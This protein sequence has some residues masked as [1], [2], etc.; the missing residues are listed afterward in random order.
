MIIQYY[1]DSLGMPRPNLV[2]M[3]QRYIHLLR[4]ALTK[5]FSDE[6]ICI[7]DRSRGGATLTDLY[8]M[9]C[10]DSAYIEENADVLIIH[11]GVVDCAPRPVPLF[12][13]N[14]ISRMPGFIKKKI[15]SLIHKNR[16]RILKAG[17]TY[18]LT[19]K[20]KFR[21]VLE[22]WLKQ[23][24]EKFYRIYFISIAPTNEGIEKHSPGFSKSINEYN[25]IAKNTI[26]Q[27]QNPKI[28]FVDVHDLFNNC[29]YELDQLVVKEDGHHLTPLGHRVCAAELIRRELSLSKKN[30]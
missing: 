30:A 8:K 25:S 5:A 27:F 15:I 19:D 7:L 22:N 21:A 20:K 23:A 12:L 24:S 9:F 2:T 17:F 26:V 4:E 1:A 18:Y 16:S 13:R 6:E 10:E 14:M 28:V 11:G 3:N 29:G